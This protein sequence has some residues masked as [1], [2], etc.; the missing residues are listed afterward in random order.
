MGSVIVSVVGSLPWSLD[1]QRSHQIQASRNPGW[2]RE[3]SLSEAKRGF[4][5]EYLR[6]ISASYGQAKSG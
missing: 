1:W 4:Y 3:D 2:Q 5:A 6:S